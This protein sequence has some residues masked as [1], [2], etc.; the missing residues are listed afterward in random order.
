M[1]T[2]INPG[3]WQGPNFDPSKPDPYGVPME[4]DVPMFESLW[5]EM[6]RFIFLSKSDDMIRKMAAVVTPPLAHRADKWNRS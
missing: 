6:V 5:T 4:V 2:Y 1:D 3:G